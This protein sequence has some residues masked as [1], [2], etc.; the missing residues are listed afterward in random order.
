MGV[1]DEEDEVEDEGVVKFDR[2]RSW[3]MMQFLSGPE[4][5]PSWDGA[6]RL[7]R[8]AAAAVSSR[9]FSIGL[10]GRPTEFLSLPEPKGRTAMDLLGDARRPPLPPAPELSECTDVGLPGP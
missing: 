6:L 10:L 5:S 3:K 1:L 2:P 8:A 9:T 4:C 7:R